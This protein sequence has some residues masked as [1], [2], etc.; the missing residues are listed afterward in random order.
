MKKGV[1]LYENS[2]KPCLLILLGDIGLLTEQYK[3]KSFCFQLKD[4]SNYN[5]IEYV[6]G[7][8]TLRKEKNRYSGFLAPK[9]FF[10]IQMKISE[11][12]KEIEKQKNE[13]PKMNFEEIQ[14]TISKEFKQLEE[15]TS[16]KCSEILFD[17]DVDN[18]PEEPPILNERIIG[19]KQLAFIIE[20][21]DGEIFGYYCN[22]QIV[23]QYGFPGQETDNKSFHFNLQSN[24][25]LKQPMKFEIKNLIF[26]GI[27]LYQ[28]STISLIKL[29]DIKLAKKNH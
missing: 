24:G 13:Q 28:K 2:K 15:W 29:G 18:W 4:N 6:F 8:K 19:K 11:E 27:R 10:V 7:G 25:R 26:G 12:Q 3:N 16:L 21:I 17:S 22:T 20:D 14:H 5:E 23:E 9:R 1:T